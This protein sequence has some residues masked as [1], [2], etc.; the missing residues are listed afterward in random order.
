VLYTAGHRMAAVKEFPVICLRCG[1]VF[2]SH[3]RVKQT[4]KFVI[5]GRVVIVGFHTP[6]PA[7][8]SCPR[9][10]GPGKPVGPEVPVQATVEAVLDAVRSASDVQILSE[11]ASEAIRHDSAREDVVAR[12]TTEVPSASGLTRRIP[13]DRL[14]RIA[15]L[16]L[17]VAILQLL[18]AV[19]PVQFGPPTGWR[20]QFGRRLFVLVEDTSYTAELR[21]TARASE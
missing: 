13:K 10:Q 5:D 21:G 15:F 18:V 7:S 4:G 11:I 14:E 12:V 8:Y 3:I 6:I 2:L 17:V 16:T 1:Y 9:C 20:D 19:H